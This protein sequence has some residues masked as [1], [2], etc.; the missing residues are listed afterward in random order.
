M[1]MALHVQIHLDDILPRIWYQGCFGWL[2]ITLSHLIRL[3]LCGIQ[4]I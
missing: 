2:G 3:A 4:V 1:L